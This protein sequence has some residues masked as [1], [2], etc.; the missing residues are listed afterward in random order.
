MQ[1]VSWIKEKEKEKK[2]RFKV[3]TFNNDSYIKLLDFSIRFGCSVLF[4]AIDT[5]IDPL[6]DPILE[7]N[8]ITEAGVEMI[9]F[10]D[11]KLEYHQ[12]F[13]LFMT[14]KI[15]NPNY[16]PEIFG[17]TMIINFNVTLMGLRD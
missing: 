5:E 13:R 8:I 9:P 6:L 2:D 17:K 12:D 15:A 10:G 1:A 7:K 14:T 3:L 11:Q 16:S 4:E